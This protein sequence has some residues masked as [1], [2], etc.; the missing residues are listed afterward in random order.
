MIACQGLFPSGGNCSTCKTIAALNQNNLSFNL[1]L[2]L[3]Y[4]LV[5]YAVKN[6]CCCYET[7]APRYVV[8]VS[9]AGNSL[10]VW[11][12]GYWDGF[13]N[14]V[15]FCVLCDFKSLWEHMLNRFQP[16]CEI[17]I[18]LLG[19]FH[20]QPAFAWILYTEPLKSHNCRSF[21]KNKT[22]QKTQYHKILIAWLWNSKYH[23]GWFVMY[24]CLGFFSSIY[25]FFI[26]CYRSTL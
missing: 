16:C 26:L 8:K 5:F 6:W 13:L 17:M 7:G 25:F 23:V 15:P 3:Y 11:L 18:R 2:T 9:S 4:S 10:D 19:S 12:F 24:V 14:C 21:L 22:K 20:S 1:A